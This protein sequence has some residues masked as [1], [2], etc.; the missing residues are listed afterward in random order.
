ML[1]FKKNLTLLQNLVEKLLD[2]NE[3]EFELF[4]KEFTAKKESY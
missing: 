1:I 4:D 3:E 2:V